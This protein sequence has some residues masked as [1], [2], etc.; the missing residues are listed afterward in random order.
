[1]RDTI[2]PFK[3]DVAFIMRRHYEQM[4]SVYASTLLELEKVVTSAYFAGIDEGAETKLEE[5]A[6]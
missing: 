1:V 4:E 2:K 3:D 6:A 5:D